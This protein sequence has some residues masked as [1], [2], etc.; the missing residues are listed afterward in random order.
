[1]T[2]HQETPPP[3]DVPAM[4]AEGEHAASIEAEPEV[5]APHTPVGPPVEP[6]SAEAPL[7]GSALPE[8]AL[9]GPPAE[10]TPAR[11]PVTKGDLLPLLC[12]LGFVF[13]CIALLVAWLNPLEPSQVRDANERIASLDARLRQIEQQST[14]A[15]VARLQ[16]RVAALEARQNADPAQVA[17]RLDVMSGRIEGLNTR[18][19]SQSEQ[20]RQALDTLS[21]RIGVMEGAQNSAASIASKLDKVARLQDAALALN[22]GQAL[23]DIPGA[24]PALAKYAQNPPP[25][26]A[27][28]RIAF[29]AAE[30]AALAAEQPDQTDAPLWQRVWEKTQALVTIRRGKE[31]VVGNQSSV[32]LANARAALDAGDLGKAVAALGSLAEA[33]R[34]A[35]AGWLSDAQSLL[36]ARAALATMAGQA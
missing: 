23:G 17:Q 3:E 9:S 35:M 36:A 31:V 24:P 28:L 25:T 29:P 19:Q 27:Q 1:M 16:A 4:I 32:A 12:G 33:P 21:A 20:T 34:K 13:L 2:E 8:P 6:S 5:A 22:A 30:R 18:D 15:D 26:E 11:A 14:A 7:P 10:R